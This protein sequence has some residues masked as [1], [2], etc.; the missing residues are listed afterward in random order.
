MIRNNA[1]Y[2]ISD[3]TLF[4]DK[5][6]LVEY[7]KRSYLSNAKNKDLLKFHLMYHMTGTDTMMFTKQ[8]LID[9]GGFDP[10]DIG[11][12]FYLI[13]KAISRKG[14]LYYLPESNIK[15]FVHKGEG[16]L[17]SG[18]QKIK[19]ENRL[20]QYKKQ[21]FNKLDSKAKRYIRMRH[22]AVLAF[23]YFRNKKIVLFLISGLESFFCAPIQCIGLIRNL[24]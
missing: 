15:A 23:A 2:S 8:Y 24:K 20:F 21:Y 1:D 11:D 7:R 5:G 6:D 18:N 14:K 12:E 22:Y 17:S 3:L 19:G 10:I 4:N 16:G 9:I 13:N